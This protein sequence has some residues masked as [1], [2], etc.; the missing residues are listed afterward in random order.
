M[1][2]IC[3]CGWFGQLTD[4][5][6]IRDERGDWALR[7]PA[8]GHLDDLRWLPDDIRQL[9]LKMAGQRHPDG[10]GEAEVAAAAV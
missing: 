1:Q 3:Y 7:C 4:R 8:C 10:I 9:V 2:E 6:P 5:A